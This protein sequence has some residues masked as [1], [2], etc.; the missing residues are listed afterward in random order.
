M[1]SAT[2][3]LLYYRDRYVYRCTGII[4]RW[5]TEG[6][7]VPLFSYRNSW[8]PLVC[9]SPVGTKL[10]KIAHTHTHKQNDMVS[11]A[12]VLG[13]DT[14]QSQTTQFLDY[15]LDTQ[16]SDGWLGPEVNTTR[17]RRLSPRCSCA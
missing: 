17:P 5:L 4:V 8:K 15:Y 9:K 2:Y 3:R 11:V 7:L 12:G 6:Y 14:L 1:D 10:G 13:I 16:G